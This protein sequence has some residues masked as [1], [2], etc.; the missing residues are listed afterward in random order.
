MSCVTIR[1]CAAEFSY[2]GGNTSLGTDERIGSK[3]TNIRYLTF[4]IKGRSKNYFVRDYKRELSTLIVM[5][6]KDAVCDILGTRE[7]GPVKER[8]KSIMH[9]KD[10]ITVCLT[11]QLNTVGVIILD[12]LP[13]LIML[14][15][16]YTRL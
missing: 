15:R 4:K 3:V 11:N 10:H 13:E 2:N 1:L 14:R 5:C 6:I 16:K 7:G 12:R 9:D 8:E